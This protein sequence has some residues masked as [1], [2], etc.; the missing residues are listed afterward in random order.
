[1]KAQKIT[2]LVCLATMMILQCHGDWYSDMAKDLSQGFDVYEVTFTGGEESGCWLTGN[3][4]EIQEFTAKLCEVC[5]QHPETKITISLQK[6]GFLTE[7]ALMSFL[8]GLAK[9]EHLYCFKGWIYVG[10]DAID[11][12]TPTIFKYI[13]PNKSLSREKFPN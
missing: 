2:K 5:N 7:K 3:P 4:K 11:T 13:H 8:E 1:M 12:E 9:I 10:K 6:V